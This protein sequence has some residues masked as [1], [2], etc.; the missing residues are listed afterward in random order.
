MCARCGDF[1]CDDCVQAGSDLCATCRERDPVGAFPLHRDSWHVDSVF[2]H[3]YLAFK[4]APSA[5]LLTLW[6]LLLPCGLLLMLPTFM[7]MPTLVPSEADAPMV[8]DRG[9]QLMISAATALTM[10]LSTP[11]IL[12]AMSFAIDRVRG[13]LGP[14]HHVRDRLKRAP[15]YAG[16]VFGSMLL[17]LPISLLQPLP[18]AATPQSAQDVFAFYRGAG[19]WTSLAAGIVGMLISLVVH[20]TALELVLDESA[21]AIEA[22]RATVRNLVRR[23]FA[24]LGT[25]L[26]LA[27][28]GYLSLSCCCLPGIVG[29]PFSVLGFV[30]M[31][32]AMR[33]PSPQ[34]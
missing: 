6:G 28:T 12:G 8:I 23:P 18:D 1:A 11:L 32:I 7:L 30:S 29:M 25:T 9:T 31:Y 3:A 20:T 26:L 16:L 27:L 21:G 33:I 2:A 10:A 5:T 13:Y 17:G 15:A 4:Q 22:L 34:H 24:A 14:R 19:L